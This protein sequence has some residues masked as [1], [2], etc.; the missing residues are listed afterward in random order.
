MLLF[1]NRYLLGAHT[2]MWE[3]HM[4]ILQT[5]KNEMPKESKE[6]SVSHSHSAF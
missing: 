5:I 1:L 6:N 2:V 3:V 4:I